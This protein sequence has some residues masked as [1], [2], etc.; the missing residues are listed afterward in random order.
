MKKVLSI[1]CVA[2]LAMSMLACENANNEGSTTESATESVA[3]SS[4]EGA[5]TL[6]AGDVFQD[7]KLRPRINKGFQAI[8][9]LV[10]Y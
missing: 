9:L 2:I 10:C 1:F 5:D 3:E 7:I 4:A 8:V 6:S